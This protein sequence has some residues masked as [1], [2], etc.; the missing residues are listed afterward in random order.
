MGPSPTSAIPVGGAKTQ[1]EIMPERFPL[2]D[3]L[4]GRVLIEFA[5]RFA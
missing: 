4:A 2:S 5:R 3:A 1:H